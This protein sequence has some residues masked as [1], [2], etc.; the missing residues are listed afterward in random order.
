[1]VIAKA[2][3]Q[4]FSPTSAAI[5]KQLEDG[6]KVV[7]EFVPTRV[8]VCDDTPPKSFEH[9]SGFLQHT[10]PFRSPNSKNAQVA[11]AVY[12]SMRIRARRDRAANAT[13]QQSALPSLLRSRSEHPQRTS[14]D[15]KHEGDPSPTSPP[16]GAKNKD[17]SNLK[18]SILGV[19]EFVADG[20]LAVDKQKT[21]HTPPAS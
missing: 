14:F 21:E 15:H 16:L 1:M 7:T 8:A 12:G 18:G 19:S 13:K 3:R 5:H 10:V 6:G 2:K 11:Q 4:L 20:G 17:A 9:N